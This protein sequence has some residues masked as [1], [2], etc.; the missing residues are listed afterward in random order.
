MRSNYL[1]SKN[2]LLRCE[3][4]PLLNCQT[5]EDHRGYETCPLFKKSVVCVLGF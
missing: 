2:L 5:Q 1:S 3:T 4:P